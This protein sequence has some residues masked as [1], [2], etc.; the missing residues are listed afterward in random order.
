MTVRVE[1]SNETP[2]IEA[3]F[4]DDWY[5]NEAN[6][7]RLL[8]NGISQ[9]PIACWSI[10]AGDPELAPQQTAVGLVGYAA[11]TD[12]VGHAVVLETLSYHTLTVVA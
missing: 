3:S 7:H 10:A 9:G 5:L 11:V 1:V 12:P 2:S 6:F 4:A 8:V